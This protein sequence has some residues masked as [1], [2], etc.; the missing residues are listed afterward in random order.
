M[1]QRFSRAAL[2]IEP[3]NDPIAKQSERVTEY[4]G[5]YD[6]RATASPKRPLRLPY[7]PRQRAPDKAW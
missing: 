5:G 7:V 2:R 6:K 1:V 3:F 4:Q